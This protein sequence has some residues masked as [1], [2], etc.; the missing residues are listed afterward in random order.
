MRSDATPQAAQATM[1]DL[2]CALLWHER[3]VGLLRG[4]CLLPGQGLWIERCRAVHT[5]GMRYPIAVFFLDANDQ[6][7]SAIG[8]VR[9][10]SW[11]V[12]HTAVSVIETRHVSAGDLCRAIDCVERSARLVRSRDDV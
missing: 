4:P 8:F 7:T 11:A 5:I 6:V 9:P 1:L 12:D 10:Y 2:R 3:A